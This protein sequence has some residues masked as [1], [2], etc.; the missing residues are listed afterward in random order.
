MTPLRIAVAKG[1]ILEQLEPLLTAAGLDA[2]ALVAPGRSLVRPLGDGVEAMIVRSQDVPLFVERGACTLGVTGLDTLRETPRELFE[3]LDLGI[4][5][6]R[7]CLAGPPELDFAAEPGRHWRI[8][9]KYVHLTEE[10]FAAA[11][12]YAEIVYMGGTLETAPE[13][14]IADAIVD[15]V[16]TGGTLKAH[17][18][19]V[20]EDILHVSTRLIA[21]RTR[22]VEDRHRVAG[23]IE[24]LADAVAR[25]GAA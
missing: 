8:A 11:G 6:C 9:T 14:G 22:L 13:A 2:D 12:R 3:L 1:R 5:R 24:A 17:G 7:L 4:G 19:V 25:R 21:G 23:L 16:E 10:A 18:L 15:L 20:H